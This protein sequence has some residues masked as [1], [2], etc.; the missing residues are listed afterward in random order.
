MSATCPLCGDRGAPA[1]FDKGGM[2]Y[3]RCGGCGFVFAR[4][5]R[6]ANFHDSLDAFEPAYLQYLQE[7]PEDGKNFDALWDRISRLRDPAGARL[8]DVGCGSGKLVRHL[9]GRGVDA[10]GIE[11]SAV[12]YGRYL[13]AE[14]RAFARTFEESA[15][16]FGPE[17]FD[18]ITALDVIEHVEDPH[19]FLAGVAGRLAPD[20][21]A[22]ISTPDAGSV[23]ARLAGRHWHHFNRY[24]LGLF[25]RATLTAA[26]GRHGLRSAW[27]ARRGR[28]RSAGY[29]SRYL[30]DFIARGRG[31]QAPG[32]LDTLVFPVNLYDTMHVLLRRAA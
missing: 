7:G 24:H 31:P 1:V 25:S 28:L 3:R 4:P 26:A 13:A 23:V 29:V 32:W 9:R 18:V 19:R 16:R 21:I 30:R 27:F 15:D 8:L 6:N 11:P 2:T 20:G 5:A 10:R 12:L 14:P 17:P 22:Y